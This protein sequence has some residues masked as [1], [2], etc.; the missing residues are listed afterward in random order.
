MEPLFAQGKIEILDNSELAR[1]LRLLERRPRP[2]GK[3][4]I[5]HP[6][7]MHDDHANSLAIAAAKAKR[8]NASYGFPTGVGHS[9]GWLNG[10][11]DYED[12]DGDSLNIGAVIRD[13]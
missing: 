7:S 10:G 5:D 9:A 6:R 8:A 13:N 1:E 4:I 3:T 2:G 11:G 12:D